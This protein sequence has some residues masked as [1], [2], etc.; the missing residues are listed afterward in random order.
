MLTGA[1]L[2]EGEVG[3]ILDGCFSHG[4][5]TVASEDRRSAE[6]LLPGFYPNA[7]S[8]HEPVGV[9][10]IPGTWIPDTTGGCS[11]DIIGWN[12]TQYLNTGRKGDRQGLD[13]MFGPPQTLH[14]LSL[15]LVLRP[16]GFY[17]A[18]MAVL[19]SSWRLWF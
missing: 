16:P 13:P 8:R 15:K 12:A 1:S 11:Q 7:A 14:L 19:C 2:D 3:W 18:L 17:K 9:Y 4:V 10:P 6:I 5:S